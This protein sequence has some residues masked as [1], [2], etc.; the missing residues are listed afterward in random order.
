MFR[1]LRIPS[2]LDRSAPVTLVAF[3]TCVAFLVSAALFISPSP[4][5]AQGEGEADSMFRFLDANRDGQ[6]EFAPYPRYH[7]PSYVPDQLKEQFA[8][9]AE[10]QLGML[11]RAD[12]WSQSLNFLG[13][14]PPGGETAPELAKGTKVRL[15]VQWREPADPNFPETDV[16]ANA[17]SLRLLRQI[18]CPLHGARVIRLEDGRFRAEAR[19]RRRAACPAGGGRTGRS[20][21]LRAGLPRPPARRS[22]KGQRPR[23][24]F[25]AGPLR[26]TLHRFAAPRHQRNGSRGESRCGRGA[27][28]GQPR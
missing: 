3:C 11:P 18:D 27:M 21:R 20:L 15:V 17:L 14:R 26:A 6:M 22:R 19:T 12:N 13:A 24:T 2:P 25:V 1:A 10:I 23:A 5:H 8:A 4:A 16:P 9:I 28:P 7:L